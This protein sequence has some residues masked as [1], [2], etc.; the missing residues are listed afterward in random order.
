[1]YSYSTSILYLFICYLGFKDLVQVGAYLAWLFRLSSDQGTFPR[2]SNSPGSYFAREHLRQRT[3][4]RAL[5][6]WN[7]FEG[8]RSRELFRGNSFEGTFSQG[9]FSKRTNSQIHY[10]AHCPCPICFASK[11]SLVSKNPHW[12]LTLDV[13]GINMKSCPLSLVTSHNQVVGNY[14]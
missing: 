14:S 5:F 9:T 12:I 7:F 1:M 2:E 4:S 8:T 11:S 10:D 6:R 3:I 13:D